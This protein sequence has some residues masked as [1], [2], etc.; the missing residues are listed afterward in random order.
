MIE[1]DLY[2]THHLLKVGCRMS[3]LKKATKGLLNFMKLSL[4][5]V[6]DWEATKMKN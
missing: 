4:K 2:P 1:L 6:W 5:I 3:A